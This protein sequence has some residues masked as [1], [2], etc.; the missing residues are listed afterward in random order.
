QEY[1][2]Q[3]LIAKMPTCA[4]MIFQL[5]S[6]ILS[7]RIKKKLC[8]PVGRISMV[9]AVKSEMSTY[10]VISDEA[11]TKWAVR[12]LAFMLV[13]SFAIAWRGWTPYRTYPAVPYIP[14]LHPS[15]VSVGVLAFACLGLLAS[16]QGRFRK[17]GL[18]VFFL[19]TAFLI[20]ED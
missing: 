14:W 12:I 15:A 4:V 7:R 10:T 17:E 5:R 19:C 3:P 8:M 18:V 20:V 11:R 6:V 1:T 2:T 9:L 16:L 13:A